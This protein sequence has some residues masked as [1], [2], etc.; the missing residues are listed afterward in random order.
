LRGKC[1]E[2]AARGDCDGFR[3]PVLSLSQDGHQYGE[4]GSGH[5]QSDPT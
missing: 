3:V 2:P 5:P 1:A 4:S